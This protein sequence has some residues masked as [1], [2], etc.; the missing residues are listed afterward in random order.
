MKLTHRYAH[1][2]ARIGE[3]LYINGG[4]VALHDP[5]EVVGEVEILYRSKRN[6]KAVFTKTI[7]RNDLLVTGAVYLSEKV[8]NTRSTY[9]TTPLDVSYGV[10]GAEDVDYTAE[11][12]PFERICGIMVGRE[13]CGDTYN[14]V[15]RVVRTD[16]RVPGMIPFRVIDTSRRDDLTGEERNLYFMRVVEG[17]L[18]KYYGKRFT[19]E[20]EINVVYEDG[21]AVDVATLVEGNDRGKLIKTYTKFTTTVSP[22]DI[23]EYC[24]ITEGNTIRSLVNSI[25]LLT[26]YPVDP[27]DKADNPDA[28]EFALVRGL[29]TLNTEDYPLKDSES[30]MDITYRFYFV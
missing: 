25:G 4:L 23:R 21:T 2:S 17:D 7:N 14:T 18:V 5:N 9:K 24:K 16:L 13:G 1:E 28:Q 19:A 15:H 10:H 8:N 22:D 27:S 3:E 30:S 26:G 12:I 29:T 6:G 20:R 11:S